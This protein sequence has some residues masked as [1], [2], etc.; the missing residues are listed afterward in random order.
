MANEQHGGLSWIP[1]FQVPLF[2]QIYVDLDDVLA[3]TVRAFSRVLAH[4][5]GRI[6]DFAEVR[7][8]DL[9]LS[10]NLGPADLHH[11]M[12]LAHK[13]DVLV[14]VEPIPG[15]IDT[16]RQWRKLGVQIIVVT[17]RPPSTA[18]VTRQWLRMH[19]V[20]HHALFFVRKYPKNPHVGDPSGS[21]SLKALA[22]SR[23]ALAVEDNP[24]M[25]NFLVRHLGIP[26]L[27]FGRPWNTTPPQPRR[28]LRHLVIRCESWAAVHAAYSGGVSA[29]STL[30]L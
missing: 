16:L 8:F 19:S 28:Q 7:S 4:E 11:F 12:Q 2:Q 15:A 1:R 22:R 18:D 29:A 23:F 17:G 30:R 26:V 27:L 13:P 10:F 21:V 6:I 3:E 9:G 24:K 25:A 5:Y 20:P 14:N